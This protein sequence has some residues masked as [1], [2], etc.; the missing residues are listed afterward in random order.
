[1]DGGVDLLEHTMIAIRIVQLQTV[2]C[3]L[4]L[5]A[6]KLEDSI[7]QQAFTDIWREMAAGGLVVYQRKD[8]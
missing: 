7:N 4:E 1:M 8:R 2:K 5:G 6:P 3:E